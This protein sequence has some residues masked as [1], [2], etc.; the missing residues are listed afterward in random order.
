MNILLGVM[1][2]VREVIHHRFRSFLT[3]LGVILGVSSLMS[4]LAITNG[5]AIAFRKN[6]ELFGGA[7]RVTLS[8]RPVPAE[9]E[10]IKDQSPGRTYADVEALRALPFVTIVSPVQR[11]PQATLEA[12]SKRLETRDLRGVEEAYL[13]SDNMEVAT[14]R[15]FNEIDQQQRHRVIVIGQQAKKNLFGSV[16]DNAV[17][18]KKVTINGIM[19]TVV[20]LFKT[21][22]HRF[23]NNRMVIPF[24]TMQELFFAARVVDGV[25]QGPDR[26]IDRIELKISD[27]SMMEDYITRMTHVLLINHKGVE[28]FGFETREEWF[29]NIEASIFGVRLSGF[30]VSGVTLI[31]AGIGITNIMMA[32][33]RERT[34]EIGVRRALGAGARDIFLQISMEALVLA[35]LGGLLGLLAGWGLI[36]LLGELLSEYA[37]PVIETNAVIFSLAA[38][39]IVGFFSGVAPALQASR[40]KPI[41]ALRFE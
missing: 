32:S 24:H 3:A 17:L 40:M 41:E 29:E 21:Y 19:F 8:N 18:G 2:G 1:E 20:G 7:E 36:H 9:Q 23:K 33:I 13:E 6:L 30:I 22:E 10:S 5:Q 28:D 4:M 38:A 25:D 12:G 35:I 16:N 31:A 39:V 34:R 26:R 11:L 15:F 37:V 14:G 27:I